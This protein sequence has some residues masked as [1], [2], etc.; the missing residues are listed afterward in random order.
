MKL[1]NITRMAQLWGQVS[2]VDPSRSLVEP[3]FLSKHNA[4]KMLAQMQIVQT[5]NKPFSNR[6]EAADA[7]QS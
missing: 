4:N 2:L 1:K 5:K 3:P 6:K 7:K